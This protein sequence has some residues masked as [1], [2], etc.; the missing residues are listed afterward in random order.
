MRYYTIKPIDDPGMVTTFA[1]QVF[2]FDGKVR[3]IPL[4]SSHNE[5]APTSRAW[6]HSRGTTAARFIR[7]NFI[8]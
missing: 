4:F 6:T 1:Q 2:Y 5:S 3:I 7:T 8:I